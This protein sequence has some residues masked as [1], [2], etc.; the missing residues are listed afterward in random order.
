MRV[1]LTLLLAAGLLLA[2]PACQPQ[3]QEMPEKPKPVAKWPN[4]VWYEI[5][6]Q[7]FAD[8]NG[9]SIGDIRGM[10]DQLPYLEELGIRG[11][12]LM[13]IHPSPS[14]HKYDVADYRDIH[15][16][17]GTLQDFKSFVAQAH[18]RDI[19][20]I[21]DLVI[22]HSARE[23]PWFQEAIKDPK[24]PYRDYYVWATPEEI[25]QMGN[26]EKEASHDSD[27]KTQW[28]MVEGEGL[29]KSELY[30]GFFWA[31]MPDLNFDNP[32]VKKEMFDIGR[33]WLEEVGVD[34]FRL[35]AARHIFPDDRVEDNHAWWIEF[36]KEMESIKPD[37]FMVGEVWEEAEKVA[38]YLPGLH[39]L[40][41]FDLGYAITATVQ[42]EQ[43]DSLIERLVQIRTLYQSTQPD[44]VDATFLTNHDQSR[45]MTE[46]QGNT[47]HAKVA[48]NLL[49]TLPGSP[50]IYY[51]EELGMLGP[52]PDPEIREP[53][54]WNATGE[55]PTTKWT[56]NKNSNP[57]TVAPLSVQQTDAN[58]LYN[59]YKMLIQMRNYSKALTFGNMEVAP[60][61][62]AGLCSF[63]RVT[64]EEALLVVHN[65]TGQTKTVQ[66]PQSLNRFN[67]I[68]MTTEASSLSNTLEL[69]VAPYSVVILK[70]LGQEAK[71]DGEEEDSAAE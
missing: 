13:P 19:K 27:N 39:A 70:P 33:F 48:A 57:E 58:S 9:D 24:S 64:D 25:G 61:L 63:I 43:A 54:V 47:S 7:S 68:S 52:K 66:L 46:L 65:L 31:G 23:I 4:A 10:T 42:Q 35:D 37:V 15:P 2:M 12:W 17:Y 11:I 34:G 1:F 49:L 36:R 69:S 51:G 55:A 28:H 20:V 5:F 41:N 22:N 14:Y 71:T 60:D 29:D 59:H 30:Y 32:A 53:F 38:P 26:M 3:K 50:F 6:V 45:I 18:A 44:F 8:S 67:E 21:I 16:D 40:F 56:P 62:G